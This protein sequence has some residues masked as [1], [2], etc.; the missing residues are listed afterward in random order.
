MVAPVAKIWMNGEMVDWAD[1]QVHVLTHTL[2]YGMGFFEGIRFY[3][4]PEGPGIFRLKDHVRRLYDSCKICRIK[5]PYD[6]D[7]IWNAHLDIVRVNGLDD[8]YIRPVV[9]LKDGPMGL[10]VQQDHPVGVF[11][12][13][14]S[15]RAYLGE[16]GLKKG[17]RTKISSFARN[18]VNS[19]M[20]KGKVNGAYVNSILSKMEA[21]QAGYDETIMLD[22]DGYVS[23]GSSENLFIVRDGE[24]RTTSLT[25]ILKGI[26]RDTVFTLAEELGYRVTEARFTRDELYVADE[27][28]FTGTAAEITPI[29]EVDD[30]TIGDGKP[31]PVTRAIQD[32]YFKAVHGKDPNHRVWVTVV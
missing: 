4:T 29:R 31:G 12:A 11:I 20:T 6:W 25:S 13:S 17:I 21:H 18:H 8:G 30:R 1:A 28:F 24:I 15:W 14:W 7:T 32:A 19:Q 23:E 2:H 16:E 5:V 10:M 9:Y 22:T 26:T 3:K 27:A